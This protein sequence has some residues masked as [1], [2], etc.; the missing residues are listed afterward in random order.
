MRWNQHLDGGTPCAPDVRQR[1]ML[2]PGPD[3]LSGTPSLHTSSEG[4]C[5]CGH[6]CWGAARVE[7]A[8]LVG[9]VLGHARVDGV[10]PD[11]SVEGQGGGPNE[12]FDA[13]VRDGEADRLGDG[14]VE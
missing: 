2:S 11:L 6:G 4:G 10:D 1:S 5:D 3:D 12:P 14:V 9:A 7:L 13:A 8:E